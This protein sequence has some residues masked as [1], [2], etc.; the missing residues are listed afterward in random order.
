MPWGTIYATRIFTL[1]VGM[2][3]GARAAH[4]EHQGKR[5][6]AFAG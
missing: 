5:V 3:Y 1:V 2:A 4:V 6:Q